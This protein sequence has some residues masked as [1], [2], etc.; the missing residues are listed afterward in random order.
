MIWKSSASMDTFKLKAKQTAEQKQPSFEL[1]IY[2]MAQGKNLK[3]CSDRM[4]VK[5]CFHPEA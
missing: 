4:K 1:G 2:A 5:K 3:V